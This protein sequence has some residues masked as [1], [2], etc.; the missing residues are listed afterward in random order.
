MIQFKE[1]FSH[2]IYSIYL[3]NFYTIIFFYNFT[4]C[5]ATVYKNVR[6]IL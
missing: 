5:R 1:I 3:F 6:N 2:A 4:Y